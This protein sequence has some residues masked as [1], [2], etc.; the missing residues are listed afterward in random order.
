M[1]INLKK[2][3]TI[4]RIISTCLWGIAIV[5]MIALLKIILFKNGIG[6][7]IRGVNLIP[8]RFITDFFVPEATIDVVLKNIIG[9]L[10]LFI[11][12]G[13][14][15]PARFEELNLKRI[16]LI[17]FGVSLSFEIIQYIIGLGLSDV[18]D[19]TL[20]TL[21]AAIGALI[22]LSFL[23]KIDKKVTVK[24]GTLIFLG[25]FGICGIVSLYLYQPNMLPTEIET[26]NKE[27]LNGLDTDSYDIQIS[28]SN[29]E[30]DTL[31]ADKQF[32]SEKYKNSDTKNSSYIISD[33]TEFFVQK[34]EFKLSPNGNIQKMTFT[35][36]KITKDKFKSIC[37]DNMVFLWMGDNNKCK[38]VL[39]MQFIEPT[40]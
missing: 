20:N 16:I 9:N 28:C 18:D 22:Y 13:I 26:I 25:I 14:L 27:A 12:L 34:K 7:V 30:K 29:I 5:Y 36:N 8:F 4:S 1:E 37:K 2:Q 32:F 24:I 35:Y 19:L 15:I 17:G 10:A 39:V 3:K 33:D 6:S 21:G 31:I 11:P 40:K 23:K 38:T